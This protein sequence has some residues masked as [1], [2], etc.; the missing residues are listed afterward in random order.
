MLTLNWNIFVQFIGELGKLEILAE[1]I[2]HRCIQQLLPRK[3]N[4]KEMAE[5]V[6][7]LCQIMRTCGRILD[8]DQGKV[9]VNR[10]IC[11]G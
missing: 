1:S 8:H 6:E 10:F 5:D 7:C 3:S 11:I 2:L 9:R 4:I